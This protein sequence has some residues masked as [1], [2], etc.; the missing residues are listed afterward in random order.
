MSRKILVAIACCLGL[1]L[2]IVLGRPSSYTVEKQVVIAAPPETVFPLLNDFHRWAEWSPWQRVDPKARQT[3]EGP[4]SG[5]GAT[6]G[7]S[8][9]EDL[10]EGTLTITGSKGP[11][12]LSIAAEFVRPAST[13]DTMDFALTPLAAGTLVS[14]TMHGHHSL[15]QKVFS[16][17]VD[18]KNFVGR[19]LEL[20]LAN[21][22][23]AVEKAAPRLP[24]PAAV[25][26][27]LAPP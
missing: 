15:S 18:A 23:D 10:G 19:D 24:A 25:D 17:V 16:L 6:F 27:G 20:G 2:L 5:A 1:L 13:G 4:S 14:W 12:H 26:A 3:F 11:E 9:N 7:W 8:G 21:L 22:K